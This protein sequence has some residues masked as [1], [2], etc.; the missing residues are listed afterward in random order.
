MSALPA[1]ERIAN[2]LRATHSMPEAQA[3]LAELRA[4]TEREVR[5]SIAADFETFGKKQVSLSWGEAYL[6]A[7]EGLC[8][9]RGGSKPCT[10][11]GAA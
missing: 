5:R 9:C 7:R 10:E 8:V 1:S 11:G 2:L 3:L 4:E 6:I